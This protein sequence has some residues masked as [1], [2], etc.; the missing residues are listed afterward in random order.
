MFACLL[1]SPLLQNLVTSAA[2]STLN[3]AT[4]D[5]KMYPAPF[6]ATAVA[7]CRLWAPSGGWLSCHWTLIC[8][9]SFI[10]AP[11]TAALSQTKPA[12]AGTSNERRAGQDSDKRNT[13]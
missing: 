1:V 7:E 2:D 4:G 3:S 12:F 5:F 6:L 8:R 11:S 10:A 9:V 13:L